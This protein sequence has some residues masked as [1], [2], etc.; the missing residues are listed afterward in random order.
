M[1]TDNLTFLQ[2][3]NQEKTDSI[4]LLNNSKTQRR[5][6]SAWLDVRYFFFHQIVRVVIYGVF[7]VGIVELSFEII[8]NGQH[9]VDK[10]RLLIDP[11]I[12]ENTVWQIGLNF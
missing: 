7:L 6:S 9:L 2:Q 12:T 3:K 10:S 11:E 5:T 1:G 8:T 4:K